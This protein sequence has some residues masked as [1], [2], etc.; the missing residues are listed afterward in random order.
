MPVVQQM[1]RQSEAGRAEADN[2]HLAAGRRLRE[3]PP[4]IEWVPAGEQRIDLETPR[5]PQYVFQGAG[6]DLR[7][8]YK[9]LPLIDARLHAVVA[10]AV[11]GCGTDRIVDGDDGEG[12]EAV[13]ARL[14][15]IHFRNLFLERA[16]REGDAEDA[17]LEGAVFLAQPPGA[18]VLGVTPL[19]GSDRGNGRRVHQPIELAGEL[20][21][22]DRR[23]FGF[24]QPFGS[25]PLHKQPFHRIKQRQLVMTRLQRPYI[26]LDAKQRADEILEVRREIDQEVGF[27]EALDRIRIAPRRHQPIMQP[28]IGLGEMGNKH[29][30]KANEPVAVV[31]IGER[32]PVLEDEAGHQG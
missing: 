32:K 11:P 4:Q 21:P 5:Q 22:V 2:E 20:R 30:I 10:D 3:G 13:A 8:V 15:Q 24:L 25:A 6:F 7:D 27:V 31:K 18:A 9:L 26:R 19:P 29:P 28:D 1:V 16:A 12:A 14:H 17:F 23:G